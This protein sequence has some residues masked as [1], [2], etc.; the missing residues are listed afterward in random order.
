[1]ELLL[2]HAEVSASQKMLKNLFL[3]LLNLAEGIGDPQVRNRGTIGGS[4]ANNDPAADYPAACLVVKC[5][6]T[7]KL[8]EKFQ[9]TNFLKECLKPTLKKVNLIEANRI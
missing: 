1:M 6:N 2:K 5:N 7:H 8:K 3:R 4:I 9:L